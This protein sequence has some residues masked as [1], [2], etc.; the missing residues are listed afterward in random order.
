MYIQ[1]NYKYLVN[2]GY[3]IDTTYYD[4]IYYMINFGYNK[5]K[6]IPTNLKKLIIYHEKQYKQIELLPHMIF[7]KRKKYEL[8]PTLIKLA[9]QYEKLRNLLNFG[10]TKIENLPRKLKALK[11][12]N[13]N[14]IAKIE[15][16]PLTLK[17]FII[18]GFNIIEKIENLNFQL[19]I[20][21]IWGCNTINKLENLPHKFKYANIN[22]NNIQKIKVN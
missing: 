3:F 18:E 6:S 7:D 11:I 21:V 10:I 8:D 20:L 13:F 16:L 9:I 5:I 12:Y 4:I 14:K 19:I 2:T 22:G 1:Y 17:T 15:N